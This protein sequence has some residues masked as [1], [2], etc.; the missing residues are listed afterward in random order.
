MK[1]LILILMVLLVAQYSYSQASNESRIGWEFY[2][3]GYAKA[4]RGDY[5]EQL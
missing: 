3:K 2:K 1:R 5:N 4:K